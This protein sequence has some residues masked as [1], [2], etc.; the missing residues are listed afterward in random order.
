MLLSKLA[1]PVE[2]VCLLEKRFCYPYSM[3][4]IAISLVLTS[5]SFAFAIIYLSVY[6]SLFLLYAGIV[7]ALLTVVK[8]S[9]YSKFGK[10]VDTPLFP[11]LD[12][13]EEPHSGWTVIFLVV[14]IF[15]GLIVP[16]LMLAIVD[17]V[18]WFT[19]LIAFV[20]GI[21]IPELILYAYSQSQKT[22]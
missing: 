10:F 15:L 11:P 5:F 13:D 14:L 1:L 21:N 20:A 7:T 8:Y 12:M 4:W 2:A 3:K 16:F 22:E 6:V 17:P 19:L 9:L 18:T